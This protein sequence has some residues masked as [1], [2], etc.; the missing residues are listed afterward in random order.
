MEV[1]LG[2]PAHGEDPIEAVEWIEK[3]P[4]GGSQSQ[5]FRLED[6]THAVVKFQQNPQGERV[7]VNEFVSCR[8]SERLNLPVN[9]AR[10]VRIDARLLA[11]PKSRGD[12]PVNFAEGIH[13]GLTRYVNAVNVDPAGPLFRDV[14]NGDELHGVLILEQLVVRGDSRQLL[15]YPSSEAGVGSGRPVWRFA[16]YDYGLA[17]GGSPAWTLDTLSQLGPVQLPTH[18]AI[19]KAYTTGGPQGVTIERLKHLTGSDFERI[20]EALSPPRWGITPEEGARIVALLEQRAQELVRQYD[21][22]YR[23]QLEAFHE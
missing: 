4:A 17:F 20:V 5:V 14:V 18:D 23:P 8:V 16:A 11:V 7:L 15:A 22:R 19:Q 2:S 3:A 10:L 21:Q 9:P 12:C 6:E 1:A 13:C